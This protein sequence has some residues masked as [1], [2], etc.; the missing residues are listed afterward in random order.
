MTT[1]RLHPAD[2]LLIAT[3]T[4][5]QGFSLDANVETR[6]EIPRMHKVAIVPIAAGQAIY[7]YGQTIGQATCDIAAGEHIHSH[8]CEMGSF[9]RDFNFCSK[10]RP[11]E[12]A[13]AS[14]ERTFEGYL[15]PNGKVGTRNFIALVTTV[16]CS[17]TA[18]RHIAEQARLQNILAD[19]P[20]VDGIVPLTHGSG[21]GMNAMSRGGVMLART[22]AGYAAH[23]NFGGVITI[24]LG[25]EAMQLSNLM[26]DY[27]LVESDLFRAYNIQDVDGT[28][29]AIAKGIEYLKDMLPRVNQ[30]RR[31]T[32]PASH[33]KLAVQCGGSDAFSGIT[34]NPA[35]GRA[36]DI[37]VAQGGTV[38]YSE[39]PEIYG[40]EH[41]LT[42]RSESPETAQDIVDLIKWWEGYTLMNGV[43]LNN[44]PSPGN[45]AGGLTT[46][47]EKSL[48]AMAKGGST[49]LR[50]V[51]QYAEQIDKKG[52]VFMDSPGFDPVSVTGQVASGANVVCFTTGRGSAFGHK[53]VPSVKLASNSELYKRMS[54]DIDI[55]C[56]KVLHGGS[57]EESG[58]EI[59]E[60]ILRVASGERTKSELLGYG[61][62]EFTPWQMGAV[63]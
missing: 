21:C 11:T 43:E 35:L 39:T 56:G 49:N 41:L 17:A 18:A 59:F 29:N 63:V 53:P 36:A 8:N 20:N 48:G 26:R 7:K 10:V 1:I 12:F 31:Q 42:Q 19:Y 3:E 45:K 16:N 32:L 44:N 52:L 24:G 40:A 6:T 13:A 9:A 27:G 55:D 2:N 25:C 62:N 57:L 37:L 60:T 51:Y 4:L 54:G 38:I 22:I 34:A 50:A 5:P 15:R 47:L 23:P 14:A 58:N 28:A 30:A 46:I 33:L 61:D